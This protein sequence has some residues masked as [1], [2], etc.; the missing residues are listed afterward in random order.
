MAGGTA[1]RY[2]C[3]V[4]ASRAPAPPLKGSNARKQEGVDNRTFDQHCDGKQ[5]EEV[6]SITRFPFLLPSDF[7]PNQ[8][9]NKKDHKRQRHVCAHECRKARTQQIPSKRTKRDETSN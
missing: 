9:P 1:P 2:N 4:A 6:N 5:C 8:Q 3:S 7:L